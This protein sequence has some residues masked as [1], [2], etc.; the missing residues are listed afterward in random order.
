MCIFNRSATLSD[1]SNN[2]TATNRYR[3]TLSSRAGSLN[4]FYAPPSLQNPSLPSSPS[5]KPN[6]HTVISPHTETLPPLSTTSKTIL[7]STISS[8]TTASPS[9][10]SK[11]SSVQVVKVND[12]KP[13]PDHYYYSEQD[14]GDYYDTIDEISI[15]SSTIKSQNPKNHSS[16]S[17]SQ[18]S[19]PIKSF[20]FPNVES[21]L[22][23]K[24]P[25]LNEPSRYDQSTLKSFF[26]NGLPSTTTEGISLASLK[27]LLT[28]T[29]TTTE[30]STST[31]KANI[32]STRDF[33]VQRQ[34]ILSFIISENQPSSFKAPSTTTTQKSSTIIAT[35]HNNI[36]LSLSNSYKQNNNNFNAFVNTQSLESTTATISKETTSPRVQTQPKTTKLL[37]SN[38]DQS[39]PIRLT[40]SSSNLD[41]YNKK[42]TRLIKDQ[43]EEIPSI[44][45]RQQSITP[46]RQK[47]QIVQVEPTTYAPLRPFKVITEVPAVAA[48]KSEFPSSTLNAIDNYSDEEDD[49][50]IVDP[51]SLLNHSRRRPYVND[52]L[53]S[54]S[55]IPTRFPLRTTTT[56]T[57]EVPSKTTMTPSTHRTIA[58]SFTSRGLVFKE[59]LN[60]T[61]ESQVNLKSIVSPYESLEA[62]RLTNA[63]RTTTPRT[64]NLVISRVSTT[65]TPLTTLAPTYRSYFFITAAPAKQNISTY[66]FPETTTILPATTIS[67]TELNNVVD[68]SSTSERI[69]GKYRPYL[70]SSSSS[71]HDVEA[72]TTYSPRLRY[73]TKTHIMSDAVVSSEQPQMRRKVIRLKS[74]LAPPQVQSSSTER[75]DVTT[76]T[77]SRRVFID[78]N[79]IASQTRDTSDFRPIITKLNE[80][81]SKLS[82]SGDLFGATTSK[83]SFNEL[84][85]ENNVESRA[86]AVVEVT[87]KPFYYT[88]YNFNNNVSNNNNNNL[89]NITESQET[90]TKKFRAT[91]EMP[92]MKVPSEEIIENDSYDEEENDEI[93]YD[94][95]DNDNETIIEVQSTPSI[96]TETT[97]IMTSTMT[98]TLMTLR[99]TESL[100]L[101]TTEN[102]K[103]LIPP[104]RA[105]RVNNAIKS[106]IIASGL[107]RRNSA[108]IKCNDVSSNAKCNEIPSRYKNNIPSSNPQNKQT[109][110]KKLN[111]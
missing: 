57:T 76:Y 53:S 74:G 48:R 35:N 14:D 68:L 79:F 90:S 42:P 56:T 55:L 78:N 103:S 7:T 44:R 67:T 5:Q 64:T 26:M 18:S 9:P 29:T 36:P 95:N 111:E 11:L 24:L 83:G 8:S 98:P 61:L 39:K 15:P 85:N 106:S 31:S 45:S 70:A 4:P 10:I 25:A 102:P 89:R 60:K 96:S 1:G 47:L 108:S 107:P 33:D 2:K 82:H 86:A 99:S 75:V 63:I 41:S 92:E 40:L 12:K 77:P 84:T 20:I 23:F 71:S 6:I 93:I 80:Y 101:S 65:A 3:L 13:L 19:S 54:T 58:Q 43:L 30:R 72:P 28:S 66:L 51:E 34:R 27:K 38:N 73:N 50:E 59:I 100:Q 49:D 21:E 32:L 109:V 91:V 69:R 17:L 87:E 88:R 105:T 46:D 94:K 16:N 52:F 81:I 110:K 104:P 37:S 97:T 22:R 62:Q